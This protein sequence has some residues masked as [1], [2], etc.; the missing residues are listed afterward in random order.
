M[1]RRDF[2]TKKPP[3]QEAPIPRLDGQ[4][5]FDPGA[6]QTV[7]DDF[8]HLVHRSP[9][10]VLLPASGRD[11]AATITW[12]TQRGVGFAA[13]G[14]RHSVFGRSQVDDGI[15][16]DMSYLDAVEDVQSD[17]VVVGAGATWSHVLAATLPYGRTPPVLTDYL[18]L[19]V[20]GTLAVGGVGGTSSTFGLQV[21]NVLELEVVTGTA[22]ELTCSAHRNRDLFDVVRGGLGQVGVVT[23]ATL[24][25]IRAPEQ[26]RRFQL[27]YPDLSAMLA[28]QRLLRDEGRFDA[29]QGA[30]TAR[31]EG[32]SNFGID[33]A[34]YFSGDRPDDGALLAGLS[35]E[36]SQRQLS[37]LSY[38]DYANRL[39]TL[40]AALRANGQWWLPHPWLTTFVGDSVVEAVVGAE[41]EALDLARDLGP[42]GQIVLSPLIGAAITAPLV[43]LPVDEHIFALN[44]IRV[45]TGDDP[46]AAA[47]LV[48]ANRAAYERISAAGGTLYPVSAMPL[49]PA[50]WRDHFGSAHERLRTAKQIHDPRNLLTPGYEVFSHDGDTE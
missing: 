6:R 32:G 10:G 28:D 33:A 16:A 5:T 37:T 43:R 15:V 36:R 35:D 23:R 25:L 13:C 31:P 49:D 27:L 34:A 21:D 42:F 39:A 12:A 3:I 46:E 47:R 45:P 7:A 24:A 29:L 8:G 14:R 2:P 18:D 48:D 9:Q 50:G 17:R 41:L 22:A 26:V 30:I 20:G 38:H 44:F 1:A 4:L 40:D 11:V 19:S